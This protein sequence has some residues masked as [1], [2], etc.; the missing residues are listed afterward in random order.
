MKSLVFFN[1]KG[2]VGK[3]TLSCNV[4][5]TL[6]T[7]HDKKVLLIDCDPQCN[8]TQLVVPENLWPHLYGPKASLP[9]L[10]DVLKPLEQGDASIDSGITPLDKSKNRFC[11]DILPGHPKVSV[12]E[13]E[14]GKAW[15]DVQAAR[16][17][18]FR[19][20]SWLHALLKKYEPQYDYVV[21]DA[22]PSLGSLNR[23]I[24]LAAN[25]FITPMGP[26]I[27]SIIGIQNI[28]E[29]LANWIKTYE[30]A[31][32]HY[33]LSDHSFNEFAVIDEPGAAGGFVG[34][35]VLQYITKSKQGQ[36]RPTTAFENIISRVPA[37]VQTRLG[38]FVRPGVDPL[39]LHLGDVPNMYSIVALAQSANAPVAALEHAD[40][41]GGA[42]PKQRQKYVEFLEN[43]SNAILVNLA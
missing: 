25:S 38:K 8:A 21:I 19:R 5:F 1:N 20:T 34:Y 33:K 28:A 17:G 27:F 41:L 43:V 13:D 31:A 24:L 4:A 16:L 26:D 6:S 30:F 32:N 9:T 36:R 22:G 23:S 7:S 29:W 15:V 14:L 37:E 40:G 2:G 42:Q 12:I 10:F 39:K 18:G 11:I 3:T 35:T